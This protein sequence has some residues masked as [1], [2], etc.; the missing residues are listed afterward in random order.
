MYYIEW[1]DYSEGRWRTYAGAPFRQL[2]DR[3]AQVE[4]ARRLN[5]N[6]PH[7]NYRVVK[8]EWES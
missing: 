8:V 1:Y 6:N 5:K 4:T 7:T 3:E 2:V